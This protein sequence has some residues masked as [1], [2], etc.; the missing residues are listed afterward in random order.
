MNIE[1][2]REID[3]EFRTSRPKLFSASP[4]DPPAEGSELD[5]VE[6]EVRARLPK[7]YREFLS[8]FG[9]G[10]F[11]FVAVFSSTPESEWYLPVQAARAQ[12]FLPQNLLPFSDDFAGGYFVFRIVDGR[13]EEKVLYWN[14]D[15]GL[16][17]T[18]Y[19]DALDYIAACAYEPA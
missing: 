13:C 2:F 19:K 15:G 10:D 5:A 9:G 8:E 17:E 11:G 14:T 4:S 7:S 12:Q 3:R 6:S 18:Q 1:A 16:I